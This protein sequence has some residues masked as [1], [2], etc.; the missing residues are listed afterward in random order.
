MGCDIHMWVEARENE[1]A[2]WVLQKPELPCAWCV[3]RPAEDCAWCGGKKTVLNYDERNYE[4]FAMLAD[5]RNYYNIPY[6][7]E[8]RGFPADMTEELK[9]WHADKSEESWP[10]D[11][12]YGRNLAEV[13][14]H[15]ASYVLLSEVLEYIK[16]D[17]GIPFKGLV[18]LEQWSEDWETR[19]N[20]NEE[21]GLSFCGSVGGYGT[22][23]VSEVDAIKIKR[24]EL[25]VAPE[26]WVFVNAHWT[27]K[28]NHQ[29]HWFI[30]NIVPVFASLS[31]DPRNIRLIFNFDS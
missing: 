19:W 27:S 21:K 10:D 13:G 28:F 20:S 15:S 11:V 16:A 2:Q 8:P 6:I 4:I 26:A 18:K 3:N 14:D 25:Q 30:D 12:L 5:V 23:I 17:H 24:G 29:N 9:A 31:A 22:L 1:N 7:A